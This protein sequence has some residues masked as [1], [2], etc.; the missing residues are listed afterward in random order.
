MAARDRPLRDRLERFTSRSLHSW[1]QPP[2]HGGDE[3]VKNC[4]L[5][6]AWG[7]LIFA[8]TFD[9]HEDIIE[10]FRRE[11]E[12][13]RDIA[14]YVWEPQVLVSK[15]PELL[16]ID[17]SVTYRLWLHDY[18]PPKR[19]PS[20]FYI[21]PA[22]RK[23]DIAAC[24]RIW[25]RYDMAQVDP[26]IAL[27]NQATR[28]F[29]YLVAEDAEDRQI[30]GTIIGIDH[31]RAFKDPDNGSSFWSLAVDP[32]RKTRGVGRALVR[33]LA[34]RYLARGR[35]YLDLSVLYDN[36]PAIKLY[37]SMGFRRVPVFAVKRKNEI[38]RP[39][40]TAG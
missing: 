5:D 25:G 35:D 1:E 7:N 36:K 2:K 33:Q 20:S 23:S 28:V 11:P 9:N 15:A 17:P 31:R 6:M 10:I 40:Y 16:F 24:N 38:N 4:V 26:D 18:R 27:K 30:D 14:F 21:R 37:R 19:R 22:E 34:E 3:I 32:D 13:R 29:S 12:G 8:Q 39:L